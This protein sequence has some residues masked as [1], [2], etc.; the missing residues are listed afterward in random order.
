MNEVQCP[1]CGSTKVRARRYK[2]DVA[3]GKRPAGMLGVCVLVGSGT[4]VASTLIVGSLYFIL[5]SAL[6]GQSIATFTFA[7]S[8][9]ITSVVTAL[10]V[11]NRYKISPV[12]KSAGNFHCM[13]CAHHWNWVEG[14]PWPRH[15]GS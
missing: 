9:A 5:L 14:Q 13:Q 7:T 1:N 12:T 8:I 11:Q 3:T 15:R 4:F 6:P 2:I 10:F